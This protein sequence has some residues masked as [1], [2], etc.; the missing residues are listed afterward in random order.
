M[1]YCN[2]CYALAGLVVGKASS[3]PF[4]QYVEDNILQPLQMRHSSFRQPLPAELDALQ[5]TGYIFTPEIQPAPQVYS[6]FLPSGGAWASGDDMGRF[7]IAQLQGGLAG[8][9]PVYDQETLAQMHQRQFSQDPR[10]EGWTYG[11]FEHIETLS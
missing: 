8:S 9:E 2:H 10:L 5:G 1:S 4:E 7:I 3:L 6:H 11:F